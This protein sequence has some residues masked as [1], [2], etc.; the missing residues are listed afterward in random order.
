MIGETPQARRELVRRTL[1][2]AAVA[3][4]TV[5]AVLVAQSHP[6]ISAWI[7]NSDQL[8]IPALVSELVV[9]PY[10][11]A[12][13]QL[14]RSTFLFPDAF[15]YWAALSLSGDPLL[16]IPLATVVILLAWLYLV[17]ESVRS[18]HALPA[19]SA[20]LWTV[21]LGLLIPLAASQYSEALTRWALV[22]YFSFANHF[23][24]FVVSVLLLRWSIGWLEDGGHRRLVVI[25]LLLTL[26][27]ISNRATWVYYLVPM[28]A[29]LAW[30]LSQRNWKP[31]RR[32]LL[33]AIVVVAAVTVGYFGENAL[34]RIT[35]MPYELSV[36]SIGHRVPRL[37]GDIAQFAVATPAVAFFLLVVLG[38][39]VAAIRGLWRTRAARSVVAIGGDANARFLFELALVAGGLGNLLAAGIAWENLGSSRY[40]TFFFFAPILLIPRLLAPLPAARIA[41]GGGTALIALC[42]YAAIVSPQPLDLRRYAQEQVREIASCVD[43]AGGGRGVGGYWT[44]RRYTFLSNESV[45]IDQ[46][47]P[48]KTDARQLLFYWGNNALSYLRGHPSIDPYR[49]IVVDALDRR[50]LEEAFGKPDE[51]KVCGSHEIWTFRDPAHIFARLFQGNFHPIQRLL[52]RDSFVNIPAGLF[53]ADVGSRE[54]VGRVADGSL[55]RQGLLLYGGYLRLGPGNYRFTVNFRSS[56]EPTSVQGNALGRFE[57]VSDLGKSVLGRAELSTRPGRHDGTATVDVH[58][59]AQADAIE[60][61]LL[62]YGTGRLEVSDVSIAT[63]IATKALRVRADDNRVHL[64]LGVKNG[65]LLTS[66]GH[67]G[68]LVYGSSVS[69]PAGL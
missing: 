30:F 52:A 16:A 37:F 1:S 45:R 57:I 11:L 26:M 13:W 60:P 24:C 53:L 63:N 29:T 21:A 17:S 8:T 51:K 22:Y 10:E 12:G 66:E 41:V 68:P 31:D 69:M 67:T 43:Q 6:V 35:A 38:V 23:S 15:L 20:V 36:L 14:P 18:T 34:N 64:P 32:S 3:I 28:S 48:W 4:A 40:L 7:T 59:S 54:G 44:A 2:I 42:A 5:I 39:Y 56:G 27:A 33:L 62:Y 47:T 50:V 55:D 25:G 61:R 19:W 58:L 46:L 49:Y 65:E 9:R